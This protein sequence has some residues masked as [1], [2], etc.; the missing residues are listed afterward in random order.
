MEEKKDISTEDKLKEY[1]KPTSKNPLGNVMLTDYH[2]NPTRKPA[3][4]AY[5]DD[6]NDEINMKTKEM[7]KEINNNNVEIEKKLFQD[8]G[9]NTMFDYSTRNFYSTANTEIPNDQQ[10]FKD[11]LYGD[12]KSSKDGSLLIP[13]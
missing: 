7:I 11:F 8:L 4:P 13:K 6:M 9:N 12:L 3:P 2:E 5:H 10:S 1:K